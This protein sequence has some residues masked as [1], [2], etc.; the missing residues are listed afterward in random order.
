MCPATP[1]IVVNTPPILVTGATGFI[2]SAVLRA[3]DVHP[4]IDVR[5]LVRRAPDGHSGQRP[6]KFVIGDLTDRTSLSDICQ[7]VHTIVHAASYVGDDPQ[8]CWAVNAAGTAALVH[9][10]RRSGVARII[11]V[12]TASVYGHGRHDGVA[13]PPSDYQPASAV[14]RSRLAA[15]QLVRDSGGWVVRPHLVYGNGDRWFVPALAALLTSAGGRIDCP[16]RIS[17]IKVD[18]LA[19]A[20]CA[21]ATLADDRLQRGTAIDVNHPNPTPVTTLVEAITNAL[22]LDIPDR[23]MSIAAIRRRLP[24]DGRSQR[25]L[26]MFAHDRWYESRHVWN[27]V[28]QEPGESF[29]TGLA[30]CVDWYRHLLRTT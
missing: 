7:G 18:D 13:P 30:H 17:T 20:L 2:G 15:E 12:S 21:L 1:R 28:G 25:H 26:A 10:A 16:A 19:R 24:E 29:E 23:P 8:R 5:A 4:D 9:A 3:L 27:V 22:E 6:S 11:Y 14:S